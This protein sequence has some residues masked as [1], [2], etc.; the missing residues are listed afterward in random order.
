MKM[1]EAEN[2]LDKI[3]KIPEVKEEI[4]ESDEKAKKEKWGK[5][6]DKGWQPWTHKQSVK[7]AIYNFLFADDPR[8][9]LA[10]PEIWTQVQEK[11]RQTT[12]AVTYSVD[13]F[14]S[15]QYRLN[16]KDLMNSA[17]QECYNELAALVDTKD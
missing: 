7:Q 4:E 13:G 14:L 12:R 3:L 6:T 15:G 2:A 5:K 17:L 10:V 9:P 1:S 11:I 16:P 8:I